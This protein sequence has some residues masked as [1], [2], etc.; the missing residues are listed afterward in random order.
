MGFKYQHQVSTLSVDHHHPTFL[1]TF[2]GGFGICAERGWSSSWSI[3]NWKCLKQIRRLRHG[4][5]IASPLLSSPCL[6]PVCPWAWAPAISAVLLLYCS[7]MVFRKWGLVWRPANSAENIWGGTRL[8]GEQN[9]YTQPWRCKRLWWPRALCIS[10]PGQMKRP[11]LL[12]MSD[13]IHWP[14]I[15]SPQGIWRKDHCLTF[16]SAPWI[17]QGRYRIHAYGMPRSD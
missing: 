16:D 15:Q 5:K 14:M 3:P 13:E 7:V 12:E 4:G 8:G 6:T 1:M 2:Q 17:L 9:N 10:P 11:A